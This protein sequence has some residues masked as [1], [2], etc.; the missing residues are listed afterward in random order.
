MSACSISIV[1]QGYELSGNPRKI[2]GRNCHCESISSCREREW[3][4]CTKMGGVSNVTREPRAED[5]PSIEPT[6]KATIPFSSAIK[7]NQKFESVDHPGPNGCGHSRLSIL[8]I[9]YAMERCSN[10]PMPCSKS[11]MIS[12]QTHPAGHFGGFGLR[13]SRMPILCITILLFLSI[14]RVKHE[15]DCR[16]HS[17]I[18]K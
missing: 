7:E 8:N 15:Q 16:C 5:W 10:R 14:R 18:R 11:Q 13:P 12:A 3:H 4:R 1:W 17:R 2:L 9:E 6:L